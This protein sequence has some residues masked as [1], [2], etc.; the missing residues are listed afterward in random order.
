MRGRSYI[1][2]NLRA[3]GPDRRPCVVWW[4]PIRGP[5]HQERD[6]I[7]FKWHHFHADA[8]FEWPRGWTRREANVR[9]ALPFG[10]L[11]AGF[12]AWR[13]RLIREHPLVGTA[14]VPD[15]APLALA[16]EHRAVRYSDWG[17]VPDKHLEEIFAMWHRMG[18]GRGHE[19]IAEAYE[20]A[21]CPLDARGHWRCPHRGARVDKLPRS[22]KWPESVFCPLHGPRSDTRTW[23]VRRAQ[24]S[25]R[26]SCTS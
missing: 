5:Y 19:R 23:T 18:T 10:D 24:E 26:I 7:G 6:L 12:G 16:I 14:A 13:D 8:R 3:E 22:R 15:V 2:P 1:V 9:H 17:A 20:G 4:I 11:P 21:R 25:G